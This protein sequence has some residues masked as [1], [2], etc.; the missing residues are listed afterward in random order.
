[1]VRL[2]TED[3][4]SA[5][6]K[7]VAGG[8]SIHK[9][10]LYWG[11]PRSTLISR[12]HGRQ[13]RRESKSTYQ[14]LSP[15]QEKHLADW[16]LAQEALGVAPT[17]TQIKELAQRVLA[18]H[19]NP[20][21][22]GKNWIESFLRRH[23]ALRT[24]RQRRIDSQRI[25]GASTEVIKSWFSTKLRIPQIQAIKPENRHNMD[26]HGILEGQGGNGL[27]VGSSE[28]RSIQQ[29][30]PGSRRWTTIL[31]CVSALGRA[32]PPLVI[33]KGKSV[34]EQWFPQELGEFKGWK[35][36]A[37]NKGWTN[38]EIAVKW[39]EDVFI[40]ET[41]PNDPKD[42]RL[43]I[44]DGHGSHTTDDFMSLCYQNNIYLL[45]LPPHSSH[46]L[47]PLD[48]GVFAPMKA[49]YRKEIGF[50]TLLTDSAPIGKRN[51]LI[52]Y[53]RA[54]KKALSAQNIKGGWRGSGLWPVCVA[55]PLTS[56]LLLENS[57]RKRP[58]ETTQVSA[59]Q[60]KALTP[61]QTPL[62]NTVLWSTPKRCID[63]E[64]QIRHFHQLGQSDPT[65]QRQLFRKIQKGY[66]EKDSLLANAEL[67]IQSLKE[68]LE[69]ARPRKKRKVQIS[70]NS[71]FA[72]IESI[73]CTREGPGQVEIEESDSE[74]S[75]VSTIES[76]CIIV[77][78]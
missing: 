62:A 42:A 37:S 61:I 9:A 43:L 58:E 16:I 56:P 77:Q 44:L 36:D 23:P 66:H 15:V 24:K 6:I 8:K 70:P 3:D 4:I 19:G 7:D 26:E 55:K 22:L 41:A 45:F 67:Q 18:L 39:L 50:L 27:V 31:E 57:N 72:S 54:R 78:N 65:T 11:I 64:R 13:S 14:K 10:A 59:S 34:Q 5:A 38:D 51:F 21:P 25:N 46:V 71:R 33:Y 73:Q 28:L 40:P 75:T 35:F 63:L 60:D 47:Q 76:D 32:I 29:K 30:Q 20:M 74:I 1:M 52:C 12:L 49:Y 48:V 53:A 68:K 69:L 2:Y 17:H